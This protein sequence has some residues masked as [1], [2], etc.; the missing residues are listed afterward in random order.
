MSQY[1]L[2][3][4]ASDAL[5]KAEPDAEKAMT[6]LAE[7]VEGHFRY[8]DR[9]ESEEEAAKFACGYEHYRSMVDIVVDYV[10]SIHKSLMKINED[11]GLVEDT[12][13]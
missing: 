12:G 3:R 6:A 8:G 2:N 10:D 7:V 1:L 5:F 9:I 4:T 13:E 11:A